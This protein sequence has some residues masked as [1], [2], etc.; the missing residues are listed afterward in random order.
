MDY[1][2]YYKVLGVDKKAT[3]EEIKKAYRKLAIKYHPDKNPG[4]KKSEEKFKEIN[5]AND[6]LGDAEKRKK[7][8]D[9]GENWQNYGANDFNNA[10]RSGGQR[11]SQQFYGS[12]ESQ[13]SDF[14]ESFFG[15]GG[16]AA[17][18]SRQRRSRQMKGD[19]F[20]A[21]ATI[22]LDDAF[23]GTSLQLSLADQKLNLKLKPGI[24]DGQVL[25]MKEKGGLGANGGPAGDLYITIHVLPHARFERRGDDLY[26]DQPL[27]VYTAVIGGKLAVQTIDKTLNINIPAGTDSGKTF[28]LK[29]TGMPRYSDPKQ[30]GDTYVRVVITVPK[31]LTSEERELWTKLAELKK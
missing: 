19:D 18:G 3:Q 28:R 7:Y 26:F 27:D 9:L 30:H 23:N 31:T 24:A 12:E 5:E 17:S 8:D 2:D 29:E 4:D 15:H 10:R 22:S 16:G 11:S 14:F 20:Q 13:F 1:K 25:K 21:E 6:V